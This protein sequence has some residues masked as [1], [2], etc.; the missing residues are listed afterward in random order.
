MEGMERF[1]SY[2]RSDSGE[3][4]QAANQAFAL[5]VEAD[6][7]FTLARFHLAVAY[8]HRRQED[9]AIPILKDLTGQHPPFLPEVYYNLA[10]AYLHTYRYDDVLKAVVALDEVERLAKEGGTRYLIYLARASKVL[11]YA[12]LGG[13]KLKHPEDFEERKKKYLLAGEELGEAVI[14]D[15]WELFLLS[16]SE[17]DDVRIEAHN[18]LGAIYMRM[19]Q[20]AEMFEKKPEEMWDKS[21]SHYKACLEIQPTLTSTLHNLGTLH[22]LQ[23]ERLLRKGQTEGA[24]R[25]F[26]TAR[27]HYV[28][29]L[30]I[31]CY[32]Q[33]PYYG[34][35]VCSVYLQDWSAALMHHELGQRQP[36]QVRPELWARLA[37]AISEKDPNIL[38]PEESGES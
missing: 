4:L 22:R 26:T 17:R 30:R 13:R 36:G 7:S 6:P 5:A 24:L 18:G 16:K 29:S 28:G 34:A 2:L 21:E 19:G 9:E 14:S 38:I 25:H 3:D 27:E 11:V 10:Q 31:N 33:F 37:Q 35:S 1:H 20:Y 8:A 12:V 15:R 32:D 23:G